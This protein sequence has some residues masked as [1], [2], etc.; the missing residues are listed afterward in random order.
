[1]GGLGDDV[2]DQ[3]YIYM[4]DKDDFSGEGVLTFPFG[5]RW[6]VEEVVVVVVVRGGP[7][8]VRVN[9]TDLTTS[10]N[11]NAL[12]FTPDGKLPDMD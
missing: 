7:K 9:D 4:E 1:M 8:S 12:S 2:V 5:R 3:V 10:A 11:Y 6:A